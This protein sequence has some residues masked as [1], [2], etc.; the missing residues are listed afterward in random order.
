MN[1]EDEIINYE[2]NVGAFS[3]QSKKGSVPV[4][5]SAVHTVKQ[6][7]EDGVKL[8]EPFTA[9]IC[10]YVSNKI[11]GYYLIKS[12]DNGIDS[13]SLEVD[14]FKELLLKYIKENEIKL[15]I[16][17]H[18][19]SSNHDFDVELGTLSNLTVD[20]TTQN[21]LME[22]LNEY[23][24]NNIALNEPFKGG[25][26]TKYIFE[27]T[28]IDIVQLE[29]NRKYRDMDFKNCENLCNALVSFSKKYIDIVSE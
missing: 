27:N 4:I 24:I 29:I 3:Y 18:G 14:D 28:S 7:K 2:K 12:I 11:N 26:I 13:N 15:L 1:F 23:G 9:A 6:H 19:A 25:G 20:I 5:F 17:V 21:A 22:C 16:D 10:Q 8:A